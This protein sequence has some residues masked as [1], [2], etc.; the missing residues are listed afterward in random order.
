MAKIIEY[1]LEKS[2]KCPMEFLKHLKFFGITFEPET[3]ETRSSDLK[4]RILA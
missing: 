1:E 3:L 2:P 4:T